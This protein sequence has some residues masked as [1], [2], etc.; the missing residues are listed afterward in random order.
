VY[1]HFRKAAAQHDIYLNLVTFVN[2]VMILVNYTY[3]DSPESQCHDTSIQMYY[4]YL[5]LMKSL[6]KLL[7]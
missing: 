6:D 3:W 1:P 4:M 2:Y 5:G 7:N